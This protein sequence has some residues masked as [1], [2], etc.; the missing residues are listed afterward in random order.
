MFE[1]L[2][3]VR[4]AGEPVDAEMDAAMTGVNR[5]DVGQY[6]RRLARNNLLIKTKRGMYDLP[7][8][9]KAA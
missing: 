7:S 5:N 8:R 1:V 3:A 4:Q 2:D 6:L 9:G